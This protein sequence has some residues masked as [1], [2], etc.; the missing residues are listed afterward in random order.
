METVI[1]ILDIISLIE[2]PKMVL[3]F[4]AMDNMKNHQ[5]IKINKK[6]DRPVCDLDLIDTYRAILP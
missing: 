1:S 6:L 5:L 3:L 2:K 4:Y